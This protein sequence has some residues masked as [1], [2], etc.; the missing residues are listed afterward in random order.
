MATASV[1]VAA[2]PQGLRSALTAS[3]AEQL[4]DRGLSV[5]LLLFLGVAL[6]VEHSIGRDMLARRLLMLFG[7]LRTTPALV[8]VGCLD[9]HSDLLQQ[10]RQRCRVSGAEHLP[11][12]V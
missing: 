6:G 7:L 2:S 10:C 3:A 4:A 11:L 12:L 5:C 8:V 9:P 1:M